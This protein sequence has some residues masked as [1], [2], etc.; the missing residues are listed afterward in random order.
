MKRISILIFTLLAVFVAKAV[1]P[2]EGTYDFRVNYGTTDNPQYIYFLWADDAHKTCKTVPGHYKVEGVPTYQG[3][4][5][6]MYFG[7]TL[8][9]LNT[10]DVKIYNSDTGN[11]VYGI[12][13]TCSIFRSSFPIPSDGK[14]PY[15]QEDGTIRYVDL[16]EISNFSFCS[17][18]DM[19]GNE[20]IIPSTVKRIGKGA[21][22]NTN[23]P[24]YPIT[25]AKAKD[26]DGNE[27]S[28]LEIIDDF[29][30]YYVDFKNEVEFPS[31]LTY[32]GE[33]FVRK[34]ANKTLVLGDPILDETDENA[35]LPEPKL[36]IAPYAFANLEGDFED[37]IINNVKSMGYGAFDQCDIKGSIYISHLETIPERAF[38]CKDQAGKAKITIGKGVSYIK[39]EAFCARTPNYIILGEDLLEIGEAA[40]FLNSTM[41]GELVIPDKVIEIGDYAF[42]RSNGVCPLIL[43]KDLTSIGAFAFS[44]VDYN[45]GSE[46]IM[47]SNVKYVGPGAFMFTNTGSNNKTDKIDWQDLY[48]YA[49]EPPDMPFTRK[50]DIVDCLDVPVEG[51]SGFG[52][53]DREA[54]NEQFNYGYLGSTTMWCYAYVCLH[55]PK[56]SYEKYH[57]HDEWGKFQCIIEDL[58]PEETFTKD[59]NGSIQKHVGYVFLSLEPNVNSDDYKSYPLTADLF[60]GEDFNFLNK[61]S[62]PVDTWEIYRAA[63]DQPDL[64]EAVGANDNEV[65][66]S[67]DVVTLLKDEENNWEVKPN[68]YGQQLILGYNTKANHSW[69][70]G[71]WKEQK[72]LVGA[73]MVF[74]CPTMTLVYNDVDTE[75]N[76]D[77]QQKL[78]P[79][80]VN[81]DSGSQSDPTAY[82]DVVTASSSYQHRAIYNSYPKFG[83][84]APAG[85]TIET[86]T[87]GHFNEDGD[88]TNDYKD[89]ETVL[90]EAQR[91]NG[92]EVGA[93]EY[94]VPM[95][96]ITENRVISLSGVLD[97]YVPGFTTSVKTVDIDGRISVTTQGLTLTVNGADDDATVTVYDTKGTLLKET[98]NKTVRLPYAG[99]YIIAVDGVTFKALVR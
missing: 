4:T 31:S 29:A 8:N 33:R 79:M 38:A 81:D 25:F 9:K 13:G 73:I 20:L 77:V 23:Y 24:A 65:D 17:N 55:V 92:E 18:L 48:V 98:V 3:S 78:R 82:D 54:L 88:Y 58:I 40:F 11:Q 91:G 1:E 44:F 51:I 15:T 12:E 14:I 35:K 87:K 76:K 84:T 43:G 62:L 68:K 6:K 85:I 26:E 47:H 86:I 69:E 52:E 2:A 56:G 59:E 27:Y 93:D 89:M 21:F 70:Q 19:Q 95:N 75:T 45:C 74:V 67:Q 99:V 97:T 50:K 5:D 63:A 90:D 16:V 30:F 94:I 41:D 32:I 57:E 71:G 61:A 22:F 60:N 53:L 66:E 49:T 46:V 80:S 36:V 10:Y 28:N 7:Y 96:A 37:V 64:G 34:L 39:A 72:S 83:L 42:F